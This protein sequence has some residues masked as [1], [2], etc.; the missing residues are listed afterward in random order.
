MTV[1]HPDSNQNKTHAHGHLK[2]NT[3]DGYDGQVIAQHH[4]QQ[5]QI[6]SSDNATTP[7]RTHIILSNHK[8]KE[9]FGPRKL[10][11]KMKTTTKT[12]KLE[13]KYQMIMKWI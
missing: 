7:T 12:K 11:S 5:Q 6:S 8:Q 2:Y 1:S 3:M 10:I 9:P 4:Q 13:K